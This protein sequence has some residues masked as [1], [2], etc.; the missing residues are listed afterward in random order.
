MLGA[1][2]RQ[3][4]RASATRAATR[5]GNALEEDDGGEERGAS[6]DRGGGEPGAAAGAAPPPA[7]ADSGGDSGEDSDSPWSAGEEEDEEEEN[8]EGEEYEE[9]EEEDEG[10]K[11]GEDEDEEEG[12]ED[13]EEDEDDEDED[14]D[15]EG[16]A[17]RV[18]S[19]QAPRVFTLSPEI[20]FLS[21]ER[22]FSGDPFSLDNI[23]KPRI[24]PT[25]SNEWSIE[26]AAHFGGE[27]STRDNA[28]SV[29][30]V[31]FTIARALSPPSDGEFR[32]TIKLMANAGREC[33][34]LST[35]PPA[36]RVRARA[37]CAADAVLAA[38]DKG[39][40]SA[41]V[42]IAISAAELEQL[43]GFASFELGTGTEEVLRAM[44]G[45]IT[46]ALGGGGGGG[47]AERASGDERRARGA[48]GARRRARERRRAALA[49]AVVAERRFRGAERALR[50]AR[51]A[52]RLRGGDGRDFDLPLPGLDLCVERRLRARHLHLVHDLRHRG[53]VARA[54]REDG[55]GG[56]RGLDF[57][58]DGRGFLREAR[59]ERVARAE[60]GL[61]AR[62]VRHRAR[63]RR[64]EL[65]ER[66]GRHARRELEAEDFG[67]LLLE[68]RLGVGVLDLELVEVD[69]VEDV[70]GRLA[71]LELRLDFRRFRA[72]RVE[73]R[74]LAVRRL[75]ARAERV[76]KVLHDRLGRHCN[77]VG[78]GGW[79]DGGCGGR[80]GETDQRCGRAVK[81]TISPS[82]TTSA[83]LSPRL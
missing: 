63:E 31:L 10:G 12:E 32:A 46:L 14:E 11:Y 20:L 74:A 59:D 40:D 15:E 77:E 76:L 28:S 17:G 36:A 42:A 53:R 62:D 37:C 81:E 25:P 33:A 26:G 51:A 23:L 2:G 39:V 58:G 18:P 13:D 55:G 49:A 35:A 44:R 75:R 38:L 8:E 65:V 5:A 41:G 22:L 27:H 66:H 16:G 4:P 64:L 21:P 60:V 67:A 1:W 30:R 48:D 47:G 43:R 71:R 24:S 78:G 70:A 45:E 34:E 52:R 72:R 29:L 7:S 3:R 56:A 79:Q 68:A 19:A 61:D 73:L 69:V 83:L 80:G 82:G 9:D 57:N 50:V 54:L 6:E